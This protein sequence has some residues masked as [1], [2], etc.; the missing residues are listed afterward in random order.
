MEVVKSQKKSK[1]KRG[2]CI[3]NRCGKKKLLHSRFCARHLHHWYKTNHPIKF[4]YANRRSQAQRRGIS[5]NWPFDDFK[6]FVEESNYLNMKGRRAEAMSLDRINNN[7]GYQPGNVQVL[8][9]GQN[10]A[11][12]TK[13]MIDCPF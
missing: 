9:F 8:S 13:Q 7:L 12:G 2:L 1:Q 5:W 3:A 11:K 4:L 10:A 6:S